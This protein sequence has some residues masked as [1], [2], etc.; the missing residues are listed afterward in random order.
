[1]VILKNTDPGMV[2]AFR[3]N[4]GPAAIFSVISLKIFSG[5][6]FLR[7]QLPNPTLIPIQRTC[8]SLFEVCEDSHV[9]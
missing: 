1:M 7:R 4:P 8:M 6:R 9:I 3:N 5:R 2:S